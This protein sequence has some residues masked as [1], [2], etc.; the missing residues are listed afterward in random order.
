[1]SE[2]SAEQLDG[3]FARWIADAYEQVGCGRRLASR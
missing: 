1:M 3:E 2:V